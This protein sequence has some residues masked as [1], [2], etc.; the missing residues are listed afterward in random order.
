MAQGATLE[1]TCAEYDVEL[2]TGKRFLSAMHDDPIRLEGREELWKQ[3][4]TEL[5][6]FHGT[7]WENAQGIASH[8]FTESTEGC[9]GRG[10]YVARKS[11]AQGF[12]MSRERHGSETG[13][14]V[15]CVV[16]FSDPKFVDGDDDGW[17]LEGHDACRSRATSRSGQMEW[18]I[19][20]ASQV[21]VVAVDKVECGSPEADNAVEIVSL[22]EGAP[23]GSSV[24]VS[25]R[26]PLSTWRCTC[27]HDAPLWRPCDECGRQ[28]PLEAIGAAM[29]VASA[30]LSRSHDEKALAAAD[31]QWVAYSAGAMGGW[32]Y[33]MDA[34]Q[35]GA[36]HPA[37]FG[38]TALMLPP[39]PPAKARWAERTG[40]FN[41]AIDCLGRSMP[42]P[43]ARP[44][45][46]VFEGSQQGR[47]HEDGVRRTQRGDDGGDDDDD[48][49]RAR[50]R[51][52]LLDFYP[53]RERHDA[54]DSRGRSMEST[55]S[56]ESEARYSEGGNSESSMGTSQYSLHSTFHSRARAEQH[57]LLRSQL[58]AA[59]KH[60]VAQRMPGNRWCFEHEGITLITDADQRRA[61]TAFRG[62]RSRHASE[63]DWDAP[64]AGGEELLPGGGP[65]EIYAEIDSAYPPTPRSP[66]VSTPRE[67]S[68]SRSVSRSVSRSRDGREGG[69]GGGGGGGGG[70]G[71]R[72]VGTAPGLGTIREYGIADDGDDIVQKVKDKARL[73]NDVALASGA[74][75][76]GVLWACDACGSRDNLAFSECFGCSAPF[77]S[78]KLDDAKRRAKA[79]LEQPHDLAAAHQA[80]PHRLGTMGGY[81]LGR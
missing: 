1:E 26:P 20:S 10:V 66:V 9:L 41:R 38:Q 18:C 61:V 80:N 75:H 42:P 68:A 70:G 43:P 64:P 29:S 15:T 77:P 31:P 13:G 12:A 5:K 24:A 60:G 54:R 78:A 56:D 71:Q 27:G 81:C 17:Q 46:R 2:E 62:R 69:S 37:A 30:V 47:W 44:P 40:A 63:V 45:K 51:R 35:A 50:K 32:A 67:R 3:L 59:L 4:S 16:T 52:F 36:P 76:A 65:F 14:L 73:A 22:E 11:K 72:Q 55:R 25:R 28:K 57:R 49:V 34:A 8:G 21:R 79:V 39:P 53:G 74:R 48:V 6:F 58:Q 23:G 33:A 7:S 19:K